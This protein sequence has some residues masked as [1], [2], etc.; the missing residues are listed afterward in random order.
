MQS[1]VENADNTMTESEEIEV[2]QEIFQSNNH[3]KVPLFIENLGP[4]E[5][6]T[7]KHVIQI[8]KSLKADIAQ[9]LGE[10]FFTNSIPLTKSNET[11]EVTVWLNLDSIENVVRTSLTF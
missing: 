8:A 4:N 9:Q 11:L 3:K 10:T 1:E 5:T 6:S 7:Q 2:N